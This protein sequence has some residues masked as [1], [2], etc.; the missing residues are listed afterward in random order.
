MKNSRITSCLLLATFV[1]LQACSSLYYSAW[2]KVGYHKRDILVSRVKAAKETQE[3]TK[4]QFASALDAFIAVSNYKGGDLEKTYR[5]LNDE[6]EASQGRAND[7]RSRIDKVEGVAEALFEEW[8]DEIDKYQ[9]ARLKSDSKKKLR[10][11]KR[12]YEPMIRAMRRAEGKL[13]PVLLAFRDQVLYL[14]HNLNAS[15]V[16]ALKGEVAS[17]EQDIQVLIA[18]MESSIDES[19]RFIDSLSAS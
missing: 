4:E 14:K 11:T 18:E 12:R 5:A 13:D 16:A 6:Y 2:E 10:D 7:L 9:S 17:V 3:E 19:S 8:E 1:F 15:A